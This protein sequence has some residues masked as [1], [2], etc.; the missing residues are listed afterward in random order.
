MQGVWC[1]D[2][3]RSL[4]NHSEKMDISKRATRLQSRTAMSRF[5][6]VCSHANLLGSCRCTDIALDGIFARRLF[7]A[8]HINVKDDW[9]SWLSI[10]LTGTSVDIVKSGGYKLSALEIEAALLQVLIYRRHLMVAEAHFCPNTT[11]PRTPTKGYISLRISWQLLKD[12]LG[13]VCPMLFVAYLKAA[14]AESHCCRIW[15]AVGC[16]L[17]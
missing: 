1:V 9:I 4:V 8:V 16:D 7:V 10:A 6:D 15:V 11:P 5:L 14:T 17:S 3:C 2:S 13:I 12:K